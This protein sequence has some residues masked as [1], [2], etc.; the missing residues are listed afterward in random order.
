MPVRVMS[1]L[2]VKVLIATNAAGGLSPDLKSGDIM[3]LRDHVNL[4]GFAGINPL[5]SINDERLE[6]LLFRPPRNNVLQMR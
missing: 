3:L 1:L 4:Q 2:G 5:A 6:N